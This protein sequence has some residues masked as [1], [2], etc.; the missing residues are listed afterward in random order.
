[1][2]SAVSTRWWLTFIVFAV[3]TIGAVAALVWASVGQPEPTLGACPPACP[4]EFRLPS[5]LLP[6]SD[7]AGSINFLFMM[8]LVLAG[9]VFVVVEGALIFTVFKFRNR[10]P[11]TA[12]QIHGDTKL[13]IAW[14]AAPALILFVIMGFTLRTMSEVRGPATG[15]VLTVKAIGHQ[16]WWEFRY[17]NQNVVTASELVVPVNTTIEV[18][19]ESVDVEHGFWAPELFGKVDAIPGYT[20]RVRFTPTSVGRGEYG[21]QCTQY[22]GTQHAQMRFSVLVK[23]QAEFD[24]WVAAQQQPAP[25]AETL[26]GDVKAGYDAFLNPQNACVACHQIDGTTA[27][28][29]IGPNLTHVGSRAHLAGGILANT[30]ANLAAWLRGP[31]D[32]KPGNKMVIRKLDDATINSL[33]AYLTSLK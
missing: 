20:T 13:E 4:Y 2:K 22:C 18:A 7:E 33:V 15:Q 14:T 25:A 9:I 28:G 8:I 32:V 6:A 10:P 31:Q 26:A 29:Q 16:F 21:G 12:L 3:V 11:E 30:P 23:T 19:L 24:A 17:P 1:L 27:A 5:T